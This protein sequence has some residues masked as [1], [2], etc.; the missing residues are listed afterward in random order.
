MAVKKEFITIRTSP[1]IKKILTD[2]E[3]S[4]FRMLSQQCIKILMDWLKGNGKLPPPNLRH[5]P[6]PPD[7]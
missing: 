6:P 3:E 7:Y 2:V 4:E 5:N 1:G